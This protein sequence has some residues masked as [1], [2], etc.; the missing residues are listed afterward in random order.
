LQHR[1]SNGAATAGRAVTDLDWS[2]HYPELL[3]ASYGGRVR[4]G[5]GPRA[6]ASQPSEAEAAESDGLVHVWNTLFP[7]VCTHCN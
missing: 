3:L 2:H 4:G 5:A 7:Q 1:F 6:D